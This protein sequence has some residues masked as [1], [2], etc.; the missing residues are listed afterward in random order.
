MASFD[1][2]R[3]PENIEQGAHGGAQFQ[4]SL[5]PMTGGAEQRNV[6]WAYSR[7]TWNI[8]YGIQ[9]AFDF[10]VVHAFFYARRAKG[11]GWRF[12]DWSDYQLNQEVIAIAD[13]QTTSFQ[14]IKTYEALGPAPYTRKITRP[15]DGTSFAF[16]LNT[17]IYLV[18]ST[19]VVYINGSVQSPST[20]SVALGGIITFNFT[21][22]TNALIAVSCDYDIPVRFDSDNFDLSLELYNAGV[23]QPLQIIELRESATSFLSQQLNLAATMNIGIS[24]GSI[25]GFPPGFA[26]FDSGAANF[27]TP[28]FNLLVIEGWGPG[29][30]GQGFN[31]GNA[32]NSIAAGVTSVS[33]FSLVANGGGAT[34]GTTAGNTGAG[35][36]GGTASGGNTTNT[37]GVAGGNPQRLTTYNS[38]NASGKGG[39]SPNGGGDTLGV[40]VGSTPVNSEVS[41]RDGTVPGGGGTGSAAAYG[42]TITFGLGV[43]TWFYMAGGAGGGY[44]KHVYHP[45][46]SGAPTV[47]SNIAYSVGAASSG[48]SDGTSKAGDG[49]PGRVKFTWS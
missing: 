3:L 25:L 14:I 24:D 31:A 28:N 21:P 15:V 46:D 13:G 8:G 34:T 1:N 18:P 23:V 12:K 38:A 4:T 30:G 47:G 45:G 19:V 32:A 20:Y 36:P 26:V 16:D 11:H 37:T 33:T 17:N 22:A 42:F 48:P 49:R 44:F 10:N 7:A 5:I 9:S 29:S 43:P 6:D 35:A 40:N 27:V 41:G 39:G 2:I